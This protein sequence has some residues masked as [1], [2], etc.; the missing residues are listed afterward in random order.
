M[1]GYDIQ[2]YLYVS[3]MCEQHGFEMEVSGDKIWLK[4]I[5]TNLGTFKSVEDIY[6]YITGFEYGFRLFNM[7][8]TK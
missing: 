2:Q 4:R 3:K 6:H 7:Q 5:G 1:N 8:G